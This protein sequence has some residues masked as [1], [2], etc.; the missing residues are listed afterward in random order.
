MESSQ[1]VSFFLLRLVHLDCVGCID[2]RKATTTGLES[3]STAMRKLNVALELQN[4]KL[5]IDPLRYPFHATGGENKR[6]FLADR[7]RQ[8]LHA[9]YSDIRARKKRNTFTN[10]IILATA[11]EKMESGGILFNQLRKNS[12]NPISIPMSDPVQSMGFWLLAQNFMYGLELQEC[13]SSSIAA[14]VAVRVDSNPLDDKYRNNILQKL[15]SVTS[16]Q[17]I[18]KLSSQTLFLYELTLAQIDYSLVARYRLEMTAFCA[19]VWETILLLGIGLRDSALVAIWR[20]RLF[21]EFSKRLEVLCSAQEIDRFKKVIDGTN[22]SINI[23]INKSI[24]RAANELGFISNSNFVSKCAMLWN[25]ISEPHSSIFLISGAVCEGKSAI[26]DTVFRGLEIFGS[27]ECALEVN[28]WVTTCRKSGLRIVE[29]I[30][31]W[32]KARKLKLKMD[33]M[34]QSS[35]FSAI[36]SVATSF[37]NVSSSQRSRGR[38]TQTVSPGRD[39]AVKDTRVFRNVHQ[40]TYFHSSLP[41]RFCLGS[42][43][44]SGQWNDGILMH[45]L[46]KLSSLSRFD[47]SGNSHSQFNN[48]HFI[49]IN[50]PI[51]YCIELL[52]T[53][54]YIQPSNVAF[55]SANEMRKRNFVACPSGELLA[56]PREVRIVL[57]TVDTSHISPIILFSAPLLNVAFS[58]YAVLSERSTQS[59]G[60]LIVKRILTV[61]VRTLY[62]W[63]GDF[64]PWLSF[65]GEIDKAIVLSGHTFLTP[66]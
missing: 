54:L 28:S 61:W 11:S 62:N 25:I 19:V 23:S 65:I 8:C 44:I 58:N 10:F 47:E 64:T 60:K 4:D 46:R 1:S 20:D 37:G 30:E 39:I 63:L 59:S 32:V 36:V 21:A 6:D 43:D 5:V 48:L 35:A 55:F 49:I 24:I 17:K 51:N 41:L 66:T 18:V 26:R 52:L 38:T 31:K 14:L 33:S 16:L 42:F 57:E 27:I 2:F 12:F 34:K 50:G 9:L 7:H 22:E 53:S 45:R 56:I 13:F 15:C 40:Y 29:A 3:L